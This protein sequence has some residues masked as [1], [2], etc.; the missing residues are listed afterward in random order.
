MSDSEKQIDLEEIISNDIEDKT[1]NE[2]APEP[3]SKKKKRTTAK[4]KPANKK[5][6]S[7]GI[8]VKEKKQGN[9]TIKTFYKE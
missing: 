6:K 7:K 3:K 9:M 4:K 5:A 8:V 2:D 1:G